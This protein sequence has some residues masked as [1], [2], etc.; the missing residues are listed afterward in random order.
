MATAPP[1]TT[2]T[3]EQLLELTDEKRYELIDGELV[4]CPL[5]SLE[6]CA[7][8]VKL[9]SI[10]NQHVVSRELGLVVDS[11]ATFQCFPD[12]PDRV[13]RA[14]LS[15]I[16]RGRIPREQ[17]EHGHCTVAPDLVIEVISPND[18]I[19]EVDEKIQDYLSAGV[20]L[21]WLINPKTRSLTVYRLR[22]K[23]A[24]FEGDEILT[25]ENVLPEL[26]FPVSSIFP[27]V[28]TVL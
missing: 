9:A 18:V 24:Y 20:E 23:R 19:F 2:I 8:A 21:V 7:I 5:M 28:N 1:V 6:S 26:Q 22:G 25:G 11:E 15:F 3:P 17:Y 12:H 13:R 16:R 4:E 27:D 10:L 14:D